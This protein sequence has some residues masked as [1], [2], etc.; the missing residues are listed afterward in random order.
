MRENNEN[1]FVCRTCGNQ[2][3][4]LSVL[5]LLEDAEKQLLVNGPEN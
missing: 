3:D 5:K 2:E 4:A 1:L